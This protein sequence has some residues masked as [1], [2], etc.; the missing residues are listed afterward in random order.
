[1][2]EEDDRPVLEPELKKA[3]AELIDQTRREPISPRLR[4]LAGQLASALERRGE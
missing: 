4:D 2:Q 1:M 3:L